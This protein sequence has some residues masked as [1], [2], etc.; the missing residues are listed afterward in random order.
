MSVCACVNRLP[1]SSQ[2]AS[3]EKWYLCDVRGD[4]GLSDVKR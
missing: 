3:F 1:S 2:D 4:F